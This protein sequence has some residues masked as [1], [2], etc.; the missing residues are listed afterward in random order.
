MKTLTDRNGKTIQ[1]EASGNIF[2]PEC[3]KPW[4]FSK[5]KLSQT[6]V[7]GRK[8]NKCYCTGDGSAYAEKFNRHYIIHYSSSISPARSVCGSCGG[9]GINHPSPVIDS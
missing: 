8:C 4:V 3:G 7:C 9:D 1:K 5:N 6:C 2:C